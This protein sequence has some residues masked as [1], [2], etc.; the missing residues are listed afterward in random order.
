MLSHFFK[1]F[2]ESANLIYFNAQ[3]QRTITIREE[4]F[5]SCLIDSENYLFV[6]YK[7]IEMSLVKAGMV[8]NVKDYEWSSYGHNTLSL[9][10]KL[11]MEH[12]QYKCLGETGACAIK[13][14]NPYLIN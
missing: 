2:K 10:T 1:V 14:T 4:R 6:L 3:Y 5:K 9:D 12:R 7:Y 13:I 11:I 8:K